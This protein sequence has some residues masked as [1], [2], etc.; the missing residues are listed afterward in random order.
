[1]VLGSARWDR[2]EF[3]ESNLHVCGRDDTKAGIYNMERCTKEE[4]GSKKKKKKKTVTLVQ[5]DYSTK[6]YD[7]YYLDYS[8]DRFSNLNCVLQSE[9]IKS[10]RF[11]SGIDLVLPST[12]YKFILWAAWV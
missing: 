1:M 5:F 11:S 2:N 9:T 7:T 4:R 6:P 8:E 10:N 3:S 12:L